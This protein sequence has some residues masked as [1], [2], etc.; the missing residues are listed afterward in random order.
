[1]SRKWFLGV[2]ALSFFSL[3]VVLAAEGSPNPTG[4]SERIAALIEQLEH[5]A[6][7]ERQAASQSLAEAGAVALPQ[8][9]ATAARGGREAAGRALAIVKQHFQN[10]EAPLKD[11]AREALSR[12]AGSEDVAVSQRAHHVLYPPRTSMLPA[13]VPFGNARNAQAMPATRTLTTHEDNGIRDVEARENGRR[14]RIQTFPNGRIQFEFTEPI[15]GRDVT[16]RIDAKDLGELRRKDAEAG[17]LYDLYQAAPRPA[18]VPRSSEPSRSAS[19]P[20]NNSRG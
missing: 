16:R 6:F 5:A 12:L 4:G 9:E 2:V 11:E 18:F 20:S 15:N 19:G 10:G 1:M 8:L 13:G 7:S 14:T 3:R 17:Q